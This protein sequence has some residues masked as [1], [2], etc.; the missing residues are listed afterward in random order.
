MSSNS[1][2]VRIFNDA[3]HS[4]PNDL[5]CDVLHKRFKQD[6]PYTQLGHH[7]L[8]ILNPYKQLELLND[9]T[10]KYYISNG[11]KDLASTASCVE[12]HIYDFATRAYYVMRRKEK[13]VAILLRQVGEREFQNIQ[14]S[15]I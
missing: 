7:R 9:A 11:Y 8:I 14:P 6:Q 1:D 10:L 13:D 4:N 2:L 5:V 12:P 15:L 3:I